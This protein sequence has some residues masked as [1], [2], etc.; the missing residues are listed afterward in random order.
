MVEG[1]IW[2]LCGLVVLG[3]SLGA[4][5][6]KELA[7]ARESAEERL[8]K[9]HFRQAEAYR[10]RRELAHAQA[11]LDREF[12]ERCARAEYSPPNSKSK[13]G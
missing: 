4:Q 13:E 8:L 12:L 10:Q 9:S 3:T 2:F 11:D 1:A 7:A 5:R 6:A